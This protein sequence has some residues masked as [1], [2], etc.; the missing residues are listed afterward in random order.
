MELL[1]QYINTANHACFGIKLSHAFEAE[2]QS[3]LD[4]NSTLTAAD[5]VLLHMGSPCHVVSG[6]GAV[7]T[8]ESLPSG[9]NIPA[10]EVTWNMA[11]LRPPMAAWPNPSA[12]PASALR[13]RSTSPYGT[14][15]MAA[16]GSA[17]A[18]AA[19]SA[20]E[21]ELGRLP[22]QHQLSIF[23]TQRIHS[24]AHNVT[25]FAHASRPSSLHTWPSHNSSS[26]SSTSNSL[27]AHLTLLEPFP[28]HHQHQHTDDHSLPSQI[29][30]NWQQSPLPTDNTLSILAQ[31]CE[32][33]RLTDDAHLSP[34]ILTSTAQNLETRPNTTASRPNT[35]ASRP[36]TTASRPNTTASRPNTIASRPDTTASRPATMTRKIST[37]RYRISAQK[38]HT[39]MPLDRQAKHPWYPTQ[40]MDDH[41]DQVLRRMRLTALSGAPLPACLASLR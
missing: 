6:K 21:G 38:M 39:K 20:A 19:A 25:A 26:S 5:C 18:A 4:F 41:P 33:L 35:T 2:R 15:V 3:P 10:S 11:P 34:Q 37:L 27:P 22:G 31:H 30:R 29:L 16:C 13:H 8:A 17:A 9:R 23:D 7:L 28:Y 36:N 32:K 12:A 1:G 40:C 24:Q 14:S